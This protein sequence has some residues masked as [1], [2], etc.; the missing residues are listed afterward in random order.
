M[1]HNNS[2]HNLLAEYKLKKEEE[3]N[4]L[5]AAFEKNISTER[6]L[7]TQVYVPSALP[8]GLHLSII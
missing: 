7:K 8:S 4:N 1:L 5:K 3:I 6:T 2:L